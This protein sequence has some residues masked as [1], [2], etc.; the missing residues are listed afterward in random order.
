MCKAFV[1]DIALP[2]QTPGQQPSFDDTTWTMG[3]LPQLAQ[4]TDKVRPGVGS[5][6]GAAIVQKRQAGD[7]S[8]ALLKGPFLYPFHRSR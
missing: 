1:K 3:D 6:V 4:L 2:L 7:L 5:L 8:A